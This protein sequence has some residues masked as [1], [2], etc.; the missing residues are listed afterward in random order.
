MN[1]LLWTHEKLTDEE[2]VKINQFQEFSDAPCHGGQTYRYEYWT[3]SQDDEL[4]EEEWEKEIDNIEKNLR[5]L[6]E[7]ISK[8][9][10]DKIKLIKLNDSSQF[11]ET[12]F[13]FD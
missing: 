9:N 6:A 7:K 13:I 11:G 5:N 4:S 1:L 3:H 2:F 8:M 10:I 12:L